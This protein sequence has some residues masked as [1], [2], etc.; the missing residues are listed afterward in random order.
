MMENGS[1]KPNERC[2]SAK[3][4]AHDLEELDPNRDYYHLYRKLYSESLRLK[5]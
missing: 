2:H 4:T 3:E 5:H 1:V